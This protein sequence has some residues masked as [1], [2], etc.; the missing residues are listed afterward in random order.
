MTAAQQSS[1][2]RIAENKDLQDALRIYCVER[3]AELVRPMREAAKV[4]DQQKVY[5][6]AAQMDLLE[7]FVSTLLNDLKRPTQQ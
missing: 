3:S 2:R 7:Q 6:F 4:H 1:L 5:D